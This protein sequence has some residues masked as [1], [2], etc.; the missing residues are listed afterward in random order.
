MRNSTSARNAHKIVLLKPVLSDISVFTL[1]RNRINENNAPFLYFNKRT[2]V[3][4]K[5]IHK[6]RNCKGGGG[7]GGGVNQNSLEINFTVVSD[8]G[9]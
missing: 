1:V 5:T 3:R 2:F 8:R 4:H 9:D 6:S 7:G